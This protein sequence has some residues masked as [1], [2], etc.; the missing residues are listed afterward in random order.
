VNNRASQVWNELLEGNRRF[1]EGRSQRWAYPESKLRELERGQHP[2]AAIIACSDS[3]VDPTVIFDQGLG[4]VF[5][6][7]VPGNIASDGVKWMVEL[8]IEEFRLP[9]VV[10]LGHSGC[11]AV[12]S[13]VDWSVGGP[14]GHMRMHVLPAVM[15]APGLGAEK[16]AQA[17]RLNAQQTV[18]QLISQCPVARRASQE[19]HTAFLAAHY[20]LAT[21]EVDE[22][23]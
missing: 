2:K 4:D 12:K 5:V 13:A 7:R 17:V 19:G 18:E 1:R 10:V 3:R 14:G 15:R 20:E 16:L 8:A 22:I 9:L 6:A 23:A 11:M 21:G